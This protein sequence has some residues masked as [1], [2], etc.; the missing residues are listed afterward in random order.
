[1]QFAERCTAC[2][3]D[4]DVLEEYGNRKLCRECFLEPKFGIVDSTPPIRRGSRFAI[5]SEPLADR[6]YHGYGAVYPGRSGVWP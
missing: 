5:P 3:D 1:M 6:Q 4:T 2:G